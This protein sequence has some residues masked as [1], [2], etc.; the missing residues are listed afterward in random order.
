MQARISQRVCVLIS[1]GLDSGVLLADM[2]RRG[3]EVFPL[4]IR[5]G[6]IW[7]RAELFWLKRFLASQRSPR[8]KTLTIAEAPAAPLL[9]RHWSLDG[10]GTPG[11]A[12]AWDSVYLPG[13][14]IV[15]LSSAALFCGRHRLNTAVFAI[16]KGNPF[17]DARPDF[18]KAMGRAA[19]KA[20]GIKLK[21]LAPYHDVEKAKV[22]GLLPGFPIHL[23]FS[24]LRPRGVKHCGR[25][26]KCAERRKGVRRAGF[27]PAAPSV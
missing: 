27:E 16:L 14:N 26:S 18:L 20:L 4:Y 5:G 15:L 8:L 10:R 11:A 25:C 6:F 1:G 9:G 22:A 7:E 19:E 17:P 21:F 23:T 13:R 24:C 3:H 12:S 2:L